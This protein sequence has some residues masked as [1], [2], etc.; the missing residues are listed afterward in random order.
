M[1]KE[2][3]CINCPRGCHLK[4]DTE[5][6]TVEGN[7]CPRGKAYGIS[8]V[9]DPQRTVTSTVKVENGVI[10]RV[11]VKTDKPVEKK[12]MFQVM[13]EINKAV[14]HA[15]IMIGT[16]IIP[17]VLGTDSNVIATKTVEVRHE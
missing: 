8:E 11:S 1:I 4:V 12:L 2:M 3:I 9:T 14:V 13:D 17:H 6:L 16:V 10:D 7:F 5:K 15:P